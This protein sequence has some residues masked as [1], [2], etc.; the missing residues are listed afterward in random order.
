MSLNMEVW[1]VL[2]NIRSMTMMLHMSI[3]EIWPLCHTYYKICEVWNLCPR[4]HWI[5]KR[6]PLSY[7]SLHTRG[8]TFDLTTLT[9]FFMLHYWIYCRYLVSLDFCHFEEVL[10]YS[11]CWDK[12]MNV[13]WFFTYQGQI[14][15]LGQIRKDLITTPTK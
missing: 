8:L 2:V 13:F 3:W 4:Y 15:H 5:C 14:S 6:W 1:H 9:L 11:E 7:R 10:L 12:S